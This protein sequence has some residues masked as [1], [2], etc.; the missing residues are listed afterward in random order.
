MIIDFQQGIVTYPTIGNQQAFLSRSGSYVALSTSNGR[1]DVTFAHGTENYFHTESDSVPAAWGPLD[2]G[3]DYWLYWDINL[4]TA[5]RTFGVS[6][7]QPVYS[8]IQ[9]T[10]PV[11]SLHWFNTSSKKM[12][13]YLHG[14]FREVIRVFA[15]KVFNSTFTP[16]GTVSGAP[17]SG[18]QAGLTIANVH[19]GRILADGL[20]K[21]I[22]RADGAFFTSES[23]FFLNGS[24]VNSIRLEASVLQ[25]TASQNIARYQVV[26]FSDFNEVRVA[27]YD[28]LQNGAIALALSNMLTTHVGDICIQGVITNTDW[29]WDTVGIPLWVDGSGNLTALDPHIDDPL[30]YPQGRAPVARVFA[31]DSIFFDQ[32][33]G[34]KG[35]AGESATSGG[36]EIASTTVAGIAKLSTAP[37]DSASPIVV[38]TNDTRMSN[39]R[40][41]LSHTHSASAISTQ[42]YQDLT[43]ATLDIQLQQLQDQVI[44]TND[45]AVTTLADLSDVTFTSPTAGQV[46]TYDSVNSNWKNQAPTILKS[47]V[48]NQIAPAS[49]WTVFH[50]Q[51]SLYPIIQAYDLES[52]PGSLTPTVSIVNANIVTL[53]FTGATA[54]RAFIVFADP[55][56]SITVEDTVAPVVTSGQTF[57][58]PEAS[59]SGVV[60]GT[61]VGTDTF[62]ITGWRFTTTGTNTSSDGYF[63]LSNVG[64]LTLTASGASSANDFET[65]P[66]TFTHGVQARDATG[67]WST[68]VNVGISL[69]D[70][71]D[72]STMFLDTFTGT[73][74]L[75]V[76][77]PEVGGIWMTGPDGWPISSWS[78]TGSGQVQHDIIPGTGTIATVQRFQSATDE[79]ALEIDFTVSSA[80]LVDGEFHIHLKDE[81][82]N[83]STDVEFTVWT[84]GAASGGSVRIGDSSGTLFSDSS[85]PELGT[86]T[87]D[88]QHTLRMEVA[89][90]EHRFLID[91]V[92]V[93]TSTIPQTLVYPRVELEYV[94]FA[95]GSPQV[96]TFSRVQVTT[97]GAAI[98]PQYSPTF[99]DYF[100]GQY[101]DA[102]LTGHIPNIGPNWIDPELPGEIGKVS[103]IDD[104]DTVA[105]DAASYVLTGSG[106][107]AEPHSDDGYVLPM[108]VMIPTASD[109]AY[110]RV[111][112]KINSIG[113]G[114]YW[115]LAN[116]L[117]ALEYES[118]KVT[119]KY[120]SEL[121]FYL[122]KNLVLDH[123]IGFDDSG[124]FYLQWNAHQFINTPPTMPAVV[125]HEYILEYRFLADKVQWIMTDTTDD[126]T[127]LLAEESTASATFATTYPNCRFYASEMA[128]SSFS[129]LVGG[130]TN[131]TDTMVLFTLIECGTYSGDEYIP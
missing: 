24:P 121:D 40:T 33:L 62:G 51:N 91:D 59:A 64:V 104:Y 42:T 56:I 99:L 25:A 32:G 31:S 12:F 89:A 117:N 81:A 102:L 72:I 2:N 105:G 127:E 54:G 115:E 92:E 97:D 43:G 124:L 10:S 14:S 114:S 119:P 73:G 38:G 49:I 66:N 68:S 1:V 90:G 46:L 70:G 30:T 71:S 37:A 13:V 18:S 48:W 122:Y 84:S 21:P 96:Y 34:G 98:P 50:N 100:Y 41:P 5:Q 86:L 61:V 106:Q 118:D 39:A 82:T 76:H 78:L 112:F 87:R 110:Y 35:D 103:P 29:E 109:G 101:N 44:A 19:A 3:V 6:T 52:P 85:I 125:G 77:T 79:Y 58:Y 131:V 53:E 47:M 130:S 88:V 67:N 45:N 129:S 75:D 93:A 26:T 7:V 83:D 128:V 126:I 16:L 55:T 69:T 17:F 107:V 20:G 4:R 95:G 28:D 8:S 111:G 108:P 123:H 74:E 9:P 113:S 23:L 120:D 94:I 65:L 27:T 36:V 63:N 80:A 15:A 116:D 11:E 22:K 57:T 60:L